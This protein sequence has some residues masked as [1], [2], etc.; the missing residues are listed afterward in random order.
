MGESLGS[1]SRT[2]VGSSSGLPDGVVERKMEGS[3]GESDKGASGARVEIVAG[4]LALGANSVEMTSAA[5]HASDIR[6]GVRCSRAARE[7]S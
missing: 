3:L 5:A 2:E 1:E 7:E 6:S 4:L